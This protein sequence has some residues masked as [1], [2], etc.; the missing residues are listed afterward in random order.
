VTPLI[1]AETPGDHRCDACGGVWM[2][3]ETFESICADDERQETILHRAERAPAAGI[4]DRYLLPCAKCRRPMRRFNYASSATLV[5]DLCDDH[6]IWLDAG[7]LRRVAEFIRAGGL[8]SWHR[9]REALPMPW[10]ATRR[11]ARPHW[12]H[13]ANVLAT[14]LLEMLF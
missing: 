8:V 4:H 13:A 10:P 14:V 2:S 11:W 5:L 9:T 12:R 6:G 7:E 3:I 1:L